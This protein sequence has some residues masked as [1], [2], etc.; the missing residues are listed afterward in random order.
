[1]SDCGCT[2]YGTCRVCPDTVHEAQG[3]RDL[4][5]R[6]GAA[7]PVPIA[8]D[9]LPAEGEPVESYEGAPWTRLYTCQ[10][11][12]YTSAVQA[13]SAEAAAR[14]AASQWWSWVAPSSRDA[15]VDVEVWPVGEAP[16][17]ITV[18]RSPPAPEAA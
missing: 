9:T 16:E 12:P 7:V 10:I 6:L 18:R 1:M 15:A 17:T 13:V 5:L 4:T 14:E 11:G 3:A 2:E 8:P